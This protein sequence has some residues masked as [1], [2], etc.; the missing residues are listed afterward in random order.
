MR[1]INQKRWY[2]VYIAPRA[3]KKVSERFSQNLISHYLP[4]KKVKRQWSDRKKEVIV[5]VINGYIFVNIKET[6]F[7]KILDVYGAIAFVSEN[8][9]PVAIP[10]YQIDRLKSMVEYADEQVEFSM[11]EFTPGEMVKIVKGPLE[12]IIVEL[13][14]FNGNHKVVVRLEGFGCALT[15]MPMSFIERLTS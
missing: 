8:K 2:A 3:E 15:T 7:R 11:E 12:G 9:L 13:I 6:E 5:P 10:D 1:D 14:D 4:T